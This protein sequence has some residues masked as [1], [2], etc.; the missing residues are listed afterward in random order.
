MKNNFVRTMLWSLVPLVIPVFGVI[1]VDG[2]NWTW[3]D[4]LFA[5]VFFVV[6]S[7]TFQFSRRIAITRLQK[8]FIGA[9]VVLT[10]VT[11]WAMVA[12]SGDGTEFRYAKYMIEGQS[13]QLNEGGTRY[14]GN[15]LKTDLNGDG[16][17][18]VVFLITQQT[19]GSGTFYYVVSAL[20]T[21]DGYV[22]S[23]GYFLGDR[24]APQTTEVSQNPKHKY[25]IVVNYAERK[26]GE[27]MTTQPS[28]GKSVYLK[29][30]PTTMQWGI[31]E[32]NFEGES[33]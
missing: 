8:N 17:E 23:D 16:R 9:L 24:I 3:H 20:N 29:L 2:W 31:V 7:L 33:R 26:T 28:V 22:G 5:W 4:F 27:P 15:D 6:A 1:F 18:D 30:D 21:K 13:V 25:V 11:I 10:F 19:G 12:T 14:F 32:P